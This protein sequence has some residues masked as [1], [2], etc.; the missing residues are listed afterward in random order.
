MLED[1]QVKR[2]SDTRY[3]ELFSHPYF[4]QGLLTRFVDE[5][6]IGELDF[7]DMEPCKNTF[8]TETYAKRESD[9]IWRIRFRRRDVYL[10]ILIEFQ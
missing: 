3:A 8:V 10:F 1:P 2:Y 4:V 7:S 9:V 6:F 5:E